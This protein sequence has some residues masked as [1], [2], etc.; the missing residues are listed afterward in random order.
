MCVVTILGCCFFASRRRHTRWAL[1]TGV[2]TCALPICISPVG[3]DIASAW[4]RV[5]KGESGIGPV[6]HF[7]TSA[8]STR[9]AGQVSGFD[10]AE[11]MPLKDVKKMDPFKIGR[12]SCRERVCKSVL[13]SVV[14]V[15]IKKKPTKQSTN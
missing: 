4:D 12:A 7:D 5:V 1:V 10:P 8:Y 2:Q 13:I 11:W 14:A 6:V 9:I 3:N 15:Y